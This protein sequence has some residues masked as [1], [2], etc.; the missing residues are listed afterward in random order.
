MA[1]ISNDSDGEKD[2]HHIGTLR[3]MIH[4]EIRREMRTQR[5]DLWDAQQKM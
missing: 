2:R 1:Y 3:L 4:Q 5:K